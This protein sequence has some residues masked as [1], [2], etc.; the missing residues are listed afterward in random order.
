M[1]HRV[2]T[3][4][5]PRNY[6]EIRPASMSAVTTATLYAQVT[7]QSGGAANVRVISES[8]L[9]RSRSCDVRIVRSRRGPKARSA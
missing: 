3:A 8:E 1:V 5:D 4:I 7:V 9:S 2:S 6:G